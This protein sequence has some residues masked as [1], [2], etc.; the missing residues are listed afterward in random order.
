MKKSFKVCSV[1]ESTLS[2]NDGQQKKHEPVPN[3]EDSLRT[4]FVENFEVN[5]MDNFDSNIR[6][7]FEDNFYDNFWDNF[8]F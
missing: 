7:N 1:L 8:G 2:V 3:F 5:F 4:I 6:V